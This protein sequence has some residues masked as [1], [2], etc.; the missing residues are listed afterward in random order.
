MSGEQEENQV[1]LEAGGV[2]DG[3]RSSR[4]WRI[5]WSGWSGNLEKNLMVLGEGGESSTLVNR[6]R[7][8]Q[9]NWI[10]GGGSRQ[11]EDQGVGKQKEDPEVW[12]AGGGSGV[13]ESWRRIM[14]SR[15]MIR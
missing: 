15:E 1:V 11:E 6:S 8:D 10:G 7:K 9:K 4:R 3:L 14:W 12:R 5:R 13:L 2:F